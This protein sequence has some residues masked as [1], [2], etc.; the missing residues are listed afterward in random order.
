MY[1]KI[2]FRQIE[3]RLDPDTDEVY[4]YGNTFPT[5]NEAIKNYN[6]L[7]MYRHECEYFKKVSASFWP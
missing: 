3:G 2:K 6:D 4:F 1:I 7:L 5:I